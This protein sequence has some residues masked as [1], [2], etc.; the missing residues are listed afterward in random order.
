M[1]SLNK[2]FFL[3]ATLNNTRTALLTWAMPSH[4]VYRHDS[5]Y[6]GLHFMLMFAEFSSHFGS[7]IS[8]SQF[9]DENS[10]TILVLADDCISVPRVICGSVPRPLS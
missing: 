4:I 2:G 7:Q 5:C 8:N 9:A 1:R 3:V 10:P 6:L